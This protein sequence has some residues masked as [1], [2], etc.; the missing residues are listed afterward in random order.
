M[1]IGDDA[2]INN[3]AALRS[4]GINPERASYYA[5]Q[6]AYDKIIVTGHRFDAGKLLIDLA[7]MSG[8]DKYSTEVRL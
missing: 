5:A 2:A 1:S 4:I 6:W 8:G 3:Y 7:P